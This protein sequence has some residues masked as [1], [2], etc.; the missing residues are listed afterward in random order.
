M[1]PAS[2]KFKRFTCAWVVLGAVIISVALW[3]PP[4]AHVALFSVLSTL[5]LGVILWLALDKIP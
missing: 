4:W 5:T 2:K 1:K 3:A